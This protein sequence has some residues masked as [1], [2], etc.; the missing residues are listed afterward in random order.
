MYRISLGHHYYRKNR[1]V[2]LVQEAFL[3]NH[4]EKS[5]EIVEA[6]DRVQV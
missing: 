3:T 2:V 4:H 5:C 1:K 6:E